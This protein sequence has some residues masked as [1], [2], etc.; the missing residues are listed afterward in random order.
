MDDCLKADIDAL[1]H[2]SDKFMEAIS[3]LNAIEKLSYFKLTNAITS[4]F[5][6]CEGAKIRLVN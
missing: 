3:S 1:K 5:K 2:L 6:R 4:A